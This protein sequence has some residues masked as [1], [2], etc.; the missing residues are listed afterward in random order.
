MLFT[1]CL[2]DVAVTSHGWI[3]RALTVILIAHITF[4]C[5]Q[6]HVTLNK[7]H[8]NACV[9]SQNPSVKQRKKTTKSGP[10]KRPGKRAPLIIQTY[11]KV[12]IWGP[13]F[14]PIFGATFSTTC[15]DFVSAAFGSGP[16]PA[17]FRGA[18]ARRLWRRPAENVSGGFRRPLHSS[19]KAKLQ[20]STA[21]SP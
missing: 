11:T 10:K 17:A 21:L 16:S 4:V 1:F 20:G 2:L 18:G 15:R 8:A 6:H 13:F 5:N 7:I 12:H 9:K 3:R 19:T 14:G